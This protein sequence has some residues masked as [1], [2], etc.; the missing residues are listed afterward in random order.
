MI[1]IPLFDEFGCDGEDGDEEIELILVNDGKVD[2]PDGDDEPQYDENAKKPRILMLIWRKVK[3]KV[4]RIFR[5]QR[6]TTVSSIAIFA[7]M[8][9]RSRAM[10]PFTGMERTTPKMPAPSTVNLRDRGCQRWH[11]RL[12]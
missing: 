7:K 3:K 2:C 8:R 5:F 10:K 6:L 4:R 1:G 11:R 9:L 12:R